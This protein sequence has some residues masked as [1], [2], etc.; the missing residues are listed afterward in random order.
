MKSLND[1]MEKAA[2]KGEKKE[3]DKAMEKNMEELKI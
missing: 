1:K 3:K 2:N